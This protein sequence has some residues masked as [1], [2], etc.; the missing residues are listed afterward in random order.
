MPHVVLLGDSIFD[1]QSYVRP[2][3]PDVI[4]QLRARLPDG[5]A[6]TLL[7]VD[8]SI[9]SSIPRQLASLPSD[10][11]HLVISVG[12]NDA[13]GH[14]GVLTAPATSVTQ[15][16]TQLAA[17][18]DQFEQSYRRMLDAVLARNLPTTVCTIYNGAFPD[19]AYQ[20]VITLS[21][22][23]WDDVILRSA[24]ERDI[25]ALD[26]RTICSDPADY[27]NPIEPSANGGAKI[28]SAITALVTTHDFTRVGHQKYA[29]I[30]PRLT[31]GT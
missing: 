8:G 27:A 12:G 22:A 5:W 29:L 7:A 23:M 4:H 25:P 11:T 20:R 21:V 14:L 28:A 19:P 3:E 10:A 13:L 15:A 2:G 31:S 16:L 24:F 9:I 1:N 17:I 18:H 6:A 30:S 26:L